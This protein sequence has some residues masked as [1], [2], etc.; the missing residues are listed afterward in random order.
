MTA[1]LHAVSTNFGGLAAGPV[2]EYASHGV[3]PMAMSCLHLPC[4][5]RAR[6]FARS[7]RTTSLRMLIWLAL[8][9]NLLPFILRA[10]L[11]KSRVHQQNV[12]CERHERK[13]S[14]KHD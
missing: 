12:D 4:F 11:L 3:S 9:D 2:V 6:S 10:L 13:D 7:P 1:H 14:A 5:L 8:V